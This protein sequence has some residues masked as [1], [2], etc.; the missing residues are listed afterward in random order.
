MT[1]P[2]PAALTEHSW[3]KE[4]IAR[5]PYSVYLDAGIY[6]ME[7]EKIFRGS[8]WNYVA[9]EAEIPKPGDFKTTAIG[10]T[11]VI[12]A[13]DKQGELHAFVNQ[14]AHRGARVCRSPQGNATNFTCIYHQWN[15]DLKGNLLGVPFRRGVVEGDHRVGGMPADFSLADHGLHKLKVEA[16]NGVVFASF[17]HQMPPVRQYLGDLMFY[18]FER[19]FD[20]RPL[21]ILGH[22]SQKIAGNWKLIFENIKDPYHASLLHVFL[23]SFGLF[24]ADQP[25]KVQMDATGRHGAL[26]S[27]RGEQKKTE[28]NADIKSLIDNFSLRDPALLDPVREFPE[29]TVVMTT[30]WP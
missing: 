11:P 30:L 13:R 7:Q 26:I 18:Y 16:L 28:D 6:R 5:V 25:S 4:G 20:G 15:Y 2:M 10:D 14:C 23:V 24:R 17:D 9:L 19:V 8:T 27:W 21:R 29:Y 3:P 1:E 22:M 12:V